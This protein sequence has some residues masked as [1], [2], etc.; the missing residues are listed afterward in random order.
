MITH[1]TSKLSHARTPRPFAA[2][3]DPTLSPARHRSEVADAASPSPTG[4]GAHGEAV[5]H[6]IRLAALF[7][8]ASLRFLWDPTG[9]DLHRSFHGAESMFIATLG[10]FLF[11]AFMMIVAFTAY[12]L[13]R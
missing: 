7:D 13:A 4:G 11:A 3:V 5:D 6:R 12:S 1:G 8:G 9:L 10:V 2:T